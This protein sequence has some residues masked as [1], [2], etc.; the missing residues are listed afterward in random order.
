MEREKLAGISFIL[1]SVFLFFV[2][3]FMTLTMWVVGSVVE[4][5]ASMN[6]TV[7]AG[8]F[9]LT[10]WL[11]VVVSVLAAIFSLITGILYITK[12]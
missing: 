9:L 11:F 2:S 8:G 10:G 1:I 12:R 7:N 3:G 4:L 6:Q 5:F